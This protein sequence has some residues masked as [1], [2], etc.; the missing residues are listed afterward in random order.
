VLTRNAPRRPRLAQLA[1][2]T[3]AAFL[4]VSKVWSQQYVLWLL[5]LA[6]LARPRWGAFLAWQ[7]AEVCYFFG[8]DGELMGASNNQIF[9]ELT[10]DIAALLRIVTLIILCVYVVLD[11]RNPERDVVR[12]VYD[13]DPDGGI[14]DG[15]PDRWIGTEP[16]LTAFV[17]T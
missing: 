1:F 14:F 9:P 3:V 12:H 13:D 7:L 6:V 11:I 4:I 10:F 17:S 8:F 2:L 16:A 5:P 15:V